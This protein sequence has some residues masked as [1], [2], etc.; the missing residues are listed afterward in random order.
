MLYIHPEPTYE[1]TEGDYTGNEDTGRP[2]VVTVRQTISSVQDIHLLLVPLTY[3]EYIVRAASDSRLA[4]IDVYH[5]SRPDA[6]ERK[7]MVCCVCGNLL[8]VWP[9]QFLVLEVV[10]HGCSS[11][12]YHSLWKSPVQCFCPSTV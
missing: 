1:F 11:L 7:L 2:V 6:A 8:C 5:R 3:A 9:S 12:K 4:G 10:S